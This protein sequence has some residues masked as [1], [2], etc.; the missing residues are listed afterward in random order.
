MSLLPGIWGQE[1]ACLAVILAAVNP[2]V[3][4]VLLA[5]PHGTAK[6][7]IARRLREML[8]DDRPFVTLPLS[9]GEETLLGGVDLERTVKEGR[10]VMLPGLMERAQGGALFIDDLHLLPRD[11][12]GL[13][14]GAEGILLVATANP[15]EGEL[16]PH[17]L[18]RF[19]LAAAMTDLRRP[20]QRRRVLDAALPPPDPAAARI[21]A[22]RIAKARDQMAALPRLSERVREAIHALVEEAACPGHRG[23]LFLAEAARA[24]AAWEAAPAVTAGHV[25]RVAPLVLDHRRR[26]AQEPPPPPQSDDAPPPND[27]A[28]DQRPPSSSNNSPGQGEQRPA[29]ST[30]GDGSSSDSA[31]REEVMAVGETFAIRRMALAKDRLRRRCSGRRTKSHVKGPD[32]RTIRTESH[33]ERGDI[34]LGASLRAAAPFQFLRGR[35]DRVL[36]EEQDLRYRRRERRMGHLVLFVVD[37]SGSM[38]AQRR[39]VAIKGAVQ[40]LLLDCYQKRDR[41]G[42]I[43]FRKDHAEL[44]LPP[45]R[46]V[47]LARRRLATVAVGGKTPLAAGLAE[48]ARV[49]EKALRREPETRILLVMLS[50]GRANHSSSG[51]K[52]LEESARA[53]RLLAAMPG[54]DAMVV[55]TED[56]R[57][58][59]RTDM[60][61]TLALDLGASYS[62]IEGLAAP[63]L[64][65]LVRQARG[66]S[67]AS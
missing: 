46:S 20:D 57:S 31:T 53:A 9:A 32:G 60:A 64:A 35:S 58:F 42:L 10:R 1:A 13:L 3:G 36:V 12:A 16:S 28:S 23:D 40:S 38:G 63:D 45:T 27:D 7:T 67:A 50:D 34:H 48:A 17:L 24:L 55:D 43:V 14:A 59:H 37:G 47:E 30:D 21:L 2:A 26:D 19:G 33:G 18:D 41:V 51:A 22:R 52:P 61:R 25:E 65:A 8:P 15:A 5:G 44:V 66:L 49:A 29:D 56:K 11:L 62:T 39:M 4:G 6:S 54:L